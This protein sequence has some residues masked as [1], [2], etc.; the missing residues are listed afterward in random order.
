MPFVI[1]GINHDS[2]PIEVRE[3]VAFAPEVMPGAL[4]DARKM[5]DCR[6][7][8]ILSTC[9]RTELYGTIDAESLLRWL[10][11]Y[12]CIPLEQLQGC[13]YRYSGE[14]AVRHMMRVACGLDSLVLGEPQILGQIKSA[15]AVARES[16]SVGSALHRVF[17]RVFTVAKKVRTETAI[18]ENP[19][20]VAYA[21]VSLASRIFTDLKRQTVLLI[22]AGETVELLARHL[23]DQGIRQLIVANRTL[24]RAQVLAENFGAEAILLADIPEHLV[25][26]DIVISSTASQLPILGKGAV[27]SALRKRRHSPM[28]MVDIAVPRDIEPQVGEL[29]DVYLY[30]VDDLRG[31]IDEGMRSREK[32]AEAAGAIVDAAAA[33]FTKESRALGAVDTIRSYRQRAQEISGAELERVLLQLDKGGDPRRLMEQ[34]VRTLTN[35]LIH[36]PTVSLKKATADGDLERLRIVREVVGLDDLADIAL[37]KKHK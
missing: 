18:G 36:A 31:V 12:H 5:P 3:R 16:G 9:N 28:F 14:A 35:K 22:G 4:G 20:S 37:E 24:S 29:D 23:L 21:A 33:E 32:A 17:Q 27:E 25:R 1:L 26:A 7:L 13:S 10:A 15:Y 19:V 8:A 2:A 11:E 30:T 6:E 34:L